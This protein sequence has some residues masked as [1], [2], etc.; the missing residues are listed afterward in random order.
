MFWTD[1]DE[2]FRIDRLFDDEEVVRFF[3][4]VLFYSLWIIFIALAR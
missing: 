4:R 3:V 1:L 2:I